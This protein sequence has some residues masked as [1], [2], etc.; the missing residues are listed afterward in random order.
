MN[1]VAGIAAAAADLGALS[2]CGQWCRWWAWQH[3]SKAAIMAVTVVELE[4]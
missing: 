1:A 4:G 3:C 2:A